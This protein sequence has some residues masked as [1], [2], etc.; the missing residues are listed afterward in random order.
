[1]NLGKNFTLEEA[2]LSH[3][4]D[5]LGIDNTMPDVLVKDAKFFTT[6]ILQP[7]RTAIGKRFL[8]S[9]WYRCPKLNKAVGGVSNSSHLSAMAVDLNI[10][11]MNTNE[12]YKL[13]LDTLKIIKIQFDQC[14]IEKNTKTGASWIHLGIKKIGNRNQAFSLKV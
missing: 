4:A 7:L 12:A 2:I 9:S 11:G 1:M 8:I 6:V 14:I 10:E 13:V 3:K 5:A